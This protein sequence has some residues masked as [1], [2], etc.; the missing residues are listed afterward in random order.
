[1]SLVELHD[2]ATGIYR[3]GGH[4]LV[5]GYGDQVVHGGGLAAQSPAAEAAPRELAN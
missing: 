2:G 3:S 1:M 5:D 4:Q